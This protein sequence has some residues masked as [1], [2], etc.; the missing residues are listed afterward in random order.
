MTS[1]VA[2]TT[3]HAAAE[4]ALEPVP[5]VGLSE[6]GVR[7]RA[8]IEERFR[9]ILDHGR[10]VMG[11][12]V[13]ELEQ[14]LRQRSGATRALA[15]S[16]GTD[17]LLMPLMAEGVGPGDA[18]FVP[19]F[20]FTATAEV[21]LL[22]GAEPVF[23]DVDRST[24]NLDFASLEREYER[25]RAEGRLRPKALL[26]VDLFGL[27]ADYER[28]GPWCAS[29]DIVLVADAA[30][31]FGGATGVGGPDAVEV[32]AMAPY[33]ATSFYPA[34]PL[35]GY[36]DGG[37]VF[38]MDPERAAELSS[39]RQHGYGERAYEIVRVGL[40]GRLDSLQAAV[41]LEKLEVFD[42][43]LE[44]RERVARAYTDGFA[45]LEGRIRCPL[46]PQGVRSAWAQYT[47]QLDERDRVQRELRAQGVPSVVYYPL[48]MHLQPAYAPYAAGAQPVSEELCG[49]VLSL[50]MNPYQTDEHTER[51]IA[52][53]RSALA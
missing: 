39:I 4:P 53:V 5:F 16:S 20:T 46:H 18:V 6:Q 47:V 19:S 51:V 29:N 45:D 52:A 41:L 8:R 28:L 38:A 31:S 42:E 49:R 50:P 36:G 25:V 35:G 15:V 21:A 24:Y 14:R 7:L 27:P 43:E 2:N 13:E 17:A 44:A 12:E 3:D 11:P 1:K 10:Y 30:Q 48:P 26:A 23:V 34:K 37:A 33:T 32:G 40:N 9:Q 22:C